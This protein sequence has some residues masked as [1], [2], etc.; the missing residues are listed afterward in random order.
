[1]VHFILRKNA[2]AVVSVAQ[3]EQQQGFHKASLAADNRQDFGE[4]R[5]LRAKLLLSTVCV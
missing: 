5:N 1:M 2:T 4:D 3:C